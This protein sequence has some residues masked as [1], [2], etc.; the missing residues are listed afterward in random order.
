MELAERCGYWPEH[1][2][3]VVK[4]ALALFD[5]TR[6]RH[7]L[8]T[9]EREW[10][11]YAAILHDIGSHIGYEQHHKHSYYLIRHGGLRGFEP[12][13]IAMIGLIARYHRKGTPKKSH[14]AY[15]DLSSAG[16]QTVKVLGGILRLA[17]GLDR[18]HAQAVAKLAVQDDGDTLRIHL[19]T[20]GD[21][22]LELWAA[23]RH[24]APLAGLFGTDMHF[25]LTPVPAPPQK[26]AQPHAEHT[27]L[28]SQLSRPPVRRRRRRRVG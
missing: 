8:G 3:Q 11:E 6:A 20:R 16:R 15:G 5:G 27:G 17:E 21:T 4:L 9:Q 14:E 18:S 1:A 13:E 24:A 23:G 28:A 26:D 25:D 2:Q 22:E 12:G 7:E 19:Q 10:L